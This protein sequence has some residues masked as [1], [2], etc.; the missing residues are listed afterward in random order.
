MPLVV[1]PESDR[2]VSIRSS[3]LV[4][5]SAASMYF[6]SLNSAFPSRSISSMRRWRAF[7]SSS[8]DGEVVEAAVDREE[9]EEEEDAVDRTLDLVGVLLLP[10]PFED[11]AEDPSISLE[12]LALERDSQSAI[13]AAAARPMIM[14]VV[15]RFVE[16][17]VDM[18]KRYDGQSVVVM[19]SGWMPQ[20]FYN[21]CMVE[22]S[23]SGKVP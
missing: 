2:V 18:V 4:N 3:A 21:A 19:S 15:C 22:S 13:P 9:D 23:A 12:R 1:L 10:L 5:I 7:S 6:L 20:G 14:Y 17:L 16:V 11:D 8:F